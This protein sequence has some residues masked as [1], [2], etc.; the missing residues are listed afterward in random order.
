[1]GVRLVPRRYS[2]EWKPPSLSGRGS[3]NSSDDSSSNSSGR[4]NGEMD[5]ATKRI[6]HRDMTI[7]VLTMAV[8]ISLLVLSKMQ[9][10]PYQYASAAFRALT[11]GTPIAISSDDI[12]TN[13]SFRKL[14]NAAHSMSTCKTMSPQEET[15][16]QVMINSQE[17]SA[18]FHLQLSE[19]R[20]AIPLEA[21]HMGILSYLTSHVLRP[22]WS[23]LDLGCGAG[24]VLSE[25]QR[26]YER[27][28]PTFGGVAGFDP[29][30]QGQVLVGVEVV[31]GYVNE[32]ADELK[33]RGIDMYRGM[34]VKWH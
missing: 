27:T 23:I 13:P 18:K 20:G 15:E 22:Q 17:H 1:M 26:H 6:L 11:Q 7:F 32:M 12:S 10:S 19:A 2:N 5:E 30:L 29:L 16:L 8:T 9:Q 3:P 24:T 28:N 31:T 4:R 14:I 21:H 25:I 33:R 34:E